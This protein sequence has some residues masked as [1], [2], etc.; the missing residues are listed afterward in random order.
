MLRQAFSTSSRALRSAPRFAVKQ[1]LLRPQIQNAPA[2]WSSRAAQP[3]VARW[4]SDAKE[5]P[6]EPQGEKASGSS[7]ANGD[8][9]A[10][11]ELKKTLETKEAEARDWKVSTTLVPLSSLSCNSRYVNPGLSC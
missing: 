1:P 8:A 11:S 7:E 4:Y 9:D 5:A 2:A 10:L 6:A 3:T